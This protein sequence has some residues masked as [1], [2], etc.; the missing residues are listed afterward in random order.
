M[1]APAL[2]LT[3]FKVAVGGG[4]AA[5][6]RLQAVGVHGQA[7][8][9]AGLA[10]FKAGGLEDLVQA[11]ALGL[12]A[13]VGAILL[14][15]M[16]KRLTWPLVRQAMEST[17]RLTA[18]VIF[19]LIGSTIFSLVFQGV[20]G[21]KWVEHL[22]SGL[23]GGQIGFLI[24]VNILIFVLALTAAPLIQHLRQIVSERLIVVAD[25]IGLGMFAIAGVA[26]A[27]RAGTVAREEV[28]VVSKVYPHNAGRQGVRDACER[29]RRRMGLDRIDLYLL[30]WRG[31]TPLAETVA[32]FEHLRSQG[33][34]RHWGVSNFDVDDLDELWAVPDGGHCAT[35]QVCYSADERGIAMVLTG[36]RH[37]RH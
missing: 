18:M 19:I 25:A 13:A 29:S 16:H 31:G 2:A 21:Q 11:L 26:E 22:L 35:N 17:M 6:A 15:W 20:D 9:A 27:M 7:H 24:V 37:F 14:A 34:I 23:P 1:G 32:A 10:P 8:A 30:H 5:L 12:F 28:F 33:R 3:A 36:V 4:R